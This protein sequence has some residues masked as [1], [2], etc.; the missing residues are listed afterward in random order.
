MFFKKNKEKL[1]V[2]L[3]DMEADISEMINIKDSRI[4]YINGAEKL[5]IFSCYSLVVLI[6]FFQFGFLINK[7]IYLF[8]YILFVLLLGYNKNTSIHKLE[9]I[10]V[11]NFVFMDIKT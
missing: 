6:Y 4:V 10:D 9:C 3:L 2:E 5:K 8:K 1:S 7:S 11:L